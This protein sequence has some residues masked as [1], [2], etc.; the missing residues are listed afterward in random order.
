M[1]TLTQA[2]KIQ[3]HTQIDLKIICSNK[4]LIFN[5]MK[6]ILINQMKM[7]LINQI[8]L[9]LNNQYKVPIL[10]NQYQV[11]KSKWYFKGHILNEN[12]I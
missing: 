5:Q 10:N 4:F 12:S 6:M 1:L 3:K 11:L 9:N 7:I 8:F 2:R